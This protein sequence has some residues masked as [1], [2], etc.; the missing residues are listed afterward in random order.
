M[1]IET[2]SARFSRTLRAAILWPVGVIFLTALLLLLLIFQLFQEIR[3]SDHSYQVLAQTRNS[4]NLIINT[5][6]NVRGY[7]LTGYPQFLASYDKTR[8]QADE[9]FLRLRVL[10]QD[11]PEQVIRVDALTRAK[12]TW[13]EHAK[14]MISHR[15]QELPVNAD[16]VK[17]GQTLM[18]DLHGQ[19]D[20]FTEVE[21]GLRDKRAYGVRRMKLALAYAGGA[22]VLL[23]SLTVAHVVRKQMMVLA[24]SY[25]TA[26]N[27]IE[28]RHAALARSERDLENQKEWLRVTLTSIGDGVIV[29]DPAGRVV[30]M[31]HESE[32]LTGWT[33]VEA[34]RQP[35]AT[36]FRIVNE[37][38]RLS[39]EDP[40]EK[41]LHEKKV[42]GLANHT[43]LLS[44]TGE[45]WPIEDSAAPICDSKGNILGVVMVFH[46][47]TDM[48]RAQNTL[49]AYSVDLEKKVADRTLSL[50]QMI[51]ELE[52]FSYTVSHDLRA[53]L[54]AM[55]GFAEAV[56]E[57][58]G[59][60]LD[61]QG[62]DYLERIKKAAKRLDRLIQDLLSY[63]RI[64]RQDISLEPLDLN[65]ILSEVI[66]HDP[67]L[68]PPAAIV[69]IEGTL[70][71][72]L[73]HES[74]L[75]QVVS[76]LLDNA[77]KFVP[78]RPLPGF[79][80]GVRNVDR[81]SVCGS[82]T[83]ALAFHPRTRSGFLRCSPN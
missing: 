54:R 80:S 10:V 40:V 19:F 21:E 45:E 41:V 78:L 65:K 74:A 42:I 46:D 14:T 7:L 23:L 75:V 60:K 64:S 18:D 39:V 27:T 71:K 11:N 56:L 25:R 50:Q 81:G 83:T 49:K 34:L 26:L 8:A 22:F 57:D 12:N 48:R 55:E 37:E 6:N 15:S 2:D 13:Y 67:N 35:L 68:N 82:R 62:A 30:L 43:L 3:W 66:E 53:P 63:T 59:E 36:V 17:M 77:V 47:A 58:Y 24:A 33:N 79:E 69:S 16:W 5:Q 44:R 32:R 38:S 61:P 28:Q 51:S 4:E 20:K 76:N 72:V 29:T 70:P 73:G 52:T 1:T 9:Q 31:N